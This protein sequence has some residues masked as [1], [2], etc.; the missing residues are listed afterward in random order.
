MTQTNT[1]K[2]Q[3]KA[4]VTESGPLSAAGAGEAAGCVSWCGFAPRTVLASMTSKHIKIFDMRGGN[5]FIIYKHT[6]I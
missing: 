3:Y 1:I 2:S 4:N 6:N 5:F